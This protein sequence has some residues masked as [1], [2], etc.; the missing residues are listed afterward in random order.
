MKSPEIVIVG[1]GIAGG[2]LGT[3]LARDGREVLILERCEEFEDRVRGE[4]LSPWGVVEANTL[5]LYDDLVVAGGHHLARHVTYDEVIDAAEA[6]S[7]PLPLGGFC[8]NVP[9]PVCLG[10][11]RGGWRSSRRTSRRSLAGR[12]RP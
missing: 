1:G 4:W 5:G 7:M 3:V 11:M 2:A 9:G 8:E 12:L 6:E 10:H